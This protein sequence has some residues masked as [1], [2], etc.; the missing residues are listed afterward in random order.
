MH[1]VIQGDSLYS[2]DGQT[3]NF[4]ALSTSWQGT[5]CLAYLGG[6]LYAIQGDMLYRADPATGEWEG[7]SSSWN[8]A[9]AIAAVP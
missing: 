8:G 4:L 1:W 7:L 5:Q 6:S 3:G 2:V 9:S